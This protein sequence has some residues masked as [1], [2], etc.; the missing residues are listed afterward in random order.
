MKL[1]S[2]LALTAGVL[3]FSPPK[4]WEN[5]AFTRSVDLSRS[6]VREDL[7]IEI[8]N[9][10]DSPNSEYYLAVP[11]FEYEKMSVLSVFPLNNP[12]QLLPLEYTEDASISS[13]GPVVNY[14]RVS[15]PPIAPRSTYKIGVSM[16][17]TNSL[18]P[19]P[20]KI[21]M[22]DEQTVVLRTNKEPLSAYDTVKSILRFTGVSEATEIAASDENRGE[23]KNGALV[24]AFG[25][26]LAFQSHPMG[27]LYKH[28]E[29]LIKVNK[30]SRGV[31]IS[32]L[33]DTIQFVEEYEITNA[34]AELDKGFSR[35][36]FMLNKNAM[37]S[38]HAITAMELLVEEG[39]RDL[40][41]TDLVGNVSTSRVFDD[42]MYIKPRYPVFGGWHYNF[43]IGWTNTLGDYLTKLSSDEYVVRIPFLNG[44]PGSPYDTVEL[45]VY[46]PEGAEIVSVD[47]PPGFKKREDGY[48]FSYFD[49]G[50]GHTKLELQ[51]EN[52]VDTLGKMDI[53]VK[54]KY[55]TAAY[56]T[57]PFNVAK[58]L[59]IAL[60]AYLALSK[61]DVTLKAKK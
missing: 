50:K 48:E 55:G 60:L 41:F 35:A 57:K 37:R 51:F 29:P 14:V 15:V 25:E 53:L 42:K 56:L 24:F 12:D 49:L 5:V 19:L 17:I 7:T 20:A 2:L 6:Y 45:S 36:D 4:D 18:E 27:L 33:G 54:Y 61:V 22:L 43:T 40:F 10:A 3:G 31:W 46:L 13:S 58:Y 39:A 32:H 1:L 47:S 9:L 38:T 11:N 52:M 21:G 34:A 28:N 59:L 44:P 30:L 16:S 23:I 8:Q 26:T